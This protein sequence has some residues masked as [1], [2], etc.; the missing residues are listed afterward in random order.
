MTRLKSCL[1]ASTRSAALTLHAFLVDIGL[2]LSLRDSVTK[3]VSNGTQV[4]PIEA[5][6]PRQAQSRSPRPPLLTL[7]PGGGETARSLSGS[8]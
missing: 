6:H 5:D 2:F 3:G 7:P 4:H 8:A 1:G